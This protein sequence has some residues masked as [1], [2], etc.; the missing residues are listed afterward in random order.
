[1]ACGKPHRE[2]T[3]TEL[4]QRYPGMRLTKDF[5][6]L[7]DESA[8][9]LR[10]DKA[11]KGFQDEFKKRGGV[12]HDEEKVLSIIP[13]KIV[14][15]CTNKNKYTTKSVI[16]TAGPWSS[17][18]LQPLGLNLPLETWRINVCYW[19]KKFGDFENFP[20]IIDDSTGEKHVYV[21]PVHEYPGLVKA[22]FHNGLKCDPDC[23]DDVFAEDSEDVKNV[24]KFISDYLPGLDGSKPAV[25][26]SCMYTVTPDWEL[27]LDKHPSHSNIVIGCGF[28][29]H[30]FKLAP[31]VGK[32]LSELA[33]GQRC[34]Y[35]I[36][37]LS[38]S[39]FGK[40][41]H[42]KANL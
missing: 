38:I 33:T 4:L 23:R 22:I 9:T 40:E 26:E 1:M 37:P 34:S 27:V 41:V 12:I 3:H 39:R 13:G 30:G 5:R 17:K 7:L 29:G 16:L 20:C 10:A 19:R 2:L 24:K 21:L 14:T 42:R 36:S 32:I 35:D 6:V 15:V 8:G 31:V 18:L 28:S 11:L 25:L